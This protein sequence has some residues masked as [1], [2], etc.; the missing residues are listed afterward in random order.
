MNGQNIKRLEDRNRAILMDELKKTRNSV[1]RR[2]FFSAALTAAAIF[3]TEYISLQFHLLLFITWLLPLVLALLSRKTKLRYYSF[4]GSCFTLVL[5]KLA[6]QNMYTLESRLIV[7]A[8]WIIVVISIFFIEHSRMKYREAFK[9]AF[10]PEALSQVFTDLDYVPDKGI[11]QQTVAST[12]MMYA[13]DRFRS[14]DFISARYKNVGFEQSDVLIQRRNHNNSKHTGA[15]ASKSGYTTTFRGRWLIFDFNKQFRSNLQIIQKGF[16]NTKKKHLFRKSVSLLNPVEMESSAFNK[17]FKVY[18]ANA[19]EAFYIITPVFMER[20]Q[21][22][23]AHN[24]GKLMF[25]FVGNKLHIAFQDGK[26][27]FEPGSALKPL[28]EEKTTQKIRG[29]IEVITQFIDELSL[30]NNLF[31]QSES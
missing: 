1:K 9:L 19:H 16:R 29:E 6:I 12:R 25:C 11:S 23:A 4:I 13:G 2:M 14:E 18:A 31:V 7:L 20:I 8:A 3:L 21:N 10:V 17:K 26:D 30:D 28:N 24:K 22:L 27:S 15:R 5:L